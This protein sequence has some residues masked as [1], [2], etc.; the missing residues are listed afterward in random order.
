[1]DQAEL[2]KQKD[3]LSRKWAT[4]GERENTT[5]EDCEKDRETKSHRDIDRKR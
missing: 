2:T 3:G 5:P 1:M 4:D